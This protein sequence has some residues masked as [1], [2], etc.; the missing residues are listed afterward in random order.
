MGLGTHFGPTAPVKGTCSQESVSA[1]SIPKRT[2]PHALR[3]GIRRWASPGSL[4]VTKGIL[5][6]S[7]LRLF[8]CLKSAGYLV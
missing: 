4:A 1:R 6:V 5:L 3:G 8:I 7:F 2:F